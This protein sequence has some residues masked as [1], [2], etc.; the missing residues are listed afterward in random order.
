MR[1]NKSNDNNIGISSFCL[2]LLLLVSTESR[3]SNT[4]FRLLGL[5][6]ASSDSLFQNSHSQS[7][8]SSAYFIIIPS[9]TRFIKDL[10]I[11]D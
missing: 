4:L 10:A 11:T 7:H 5:I 6:S 1:V 3:N 2:L 9:A 8:H